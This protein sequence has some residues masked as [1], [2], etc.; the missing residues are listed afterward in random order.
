MKT[1][2]RWMP[3]LMVMLVIFLLSGIEAEDMPTLGF[4]DT[5]VK[6]GGHLLGYGILALCFWYGMHW[7]LQRTWTALCLTILYAI[8]D[9]VHQLFVPGRHASL[10]DILVFD[11]GGALLF[12]VIL[13]ILRNRKPDADFPPTNANLQG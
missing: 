7:E 10:V 4:W 2:V 3:A 6:K 1:L 13:R 11:T 9:E 8:T 12:L 5:L